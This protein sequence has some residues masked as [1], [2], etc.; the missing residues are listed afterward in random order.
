VLANHADIQSGWLLA[1][2]R[3]VAESAVDAARQLGMSPQAQR[4]LRQAALLRDI[5]RVGISIP[6]WDHPAPL[7]DSDLDHIRL[8]AMLPAQILRRSPRLSQG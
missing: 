4:A 3:R 1:H 6:V 7:N 2:P 8:H 5:G